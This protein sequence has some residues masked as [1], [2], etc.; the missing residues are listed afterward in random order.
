MV[1]VRTAVHAD[2]DAI[3]RVQVETWRAAY[4][5]LMPDEAIA[6][7]DLEG[8]QRMWREGL[9]REPRPGSATFVAELEGEVVGFASVGRSRDEEAEN[10]GELYAIYLLPSCW[11]RGIGRALIERAEESMRA[12]GF[13]RAILWVME[14]NE[15]GERFYR[16]AGWSSGG[17]KLE[18]FQGAEVAE[19]RYRKA[20]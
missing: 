3:G 20:L 9:A 19:L 16:A 4:R 12:S 6:G 7:F 18:M 2:A 5:G 14:G 13:E 8:R 15:R 1:T 17:R 11:D 10:E